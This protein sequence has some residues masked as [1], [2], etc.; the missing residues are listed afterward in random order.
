MTATINWTISTCDRDVATGF[1]KTAHWQCN[2][3]DGDFSG[4]V[5]ATCSWAVGTPSIPYAEVTE[6][7]VLNWIWASGVD[8]EA[9]EA[10]VSAQIEAQKNPVTASG[11]PW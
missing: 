4:S 9:T 1:I 10:A 6:A 2:G 5:Y 3:V 8:K 11:T 7:E